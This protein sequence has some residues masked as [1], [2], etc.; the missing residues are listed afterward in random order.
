[1]DMGMKVSFVGLVIGYVGTFA[2]LV[3]CWM[4]GRVG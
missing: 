3:W 1:M 4:V 2:F